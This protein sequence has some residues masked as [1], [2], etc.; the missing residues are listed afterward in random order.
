[1]KIYKTLLPAIILI[2]GFLLPSCDERMEELNTDPL[3]LSGIPNEYM[4]ASAVRKTFGDPSDEGR[5]ASQYA[6]VYVTNSEWRR[7]DGYDD[8]HSQDIYKMMFSYWYTEPVRYIRR[9]LDLTASGPDA[10]TV[11]HA[12][13]MVVEALC[14]SQITD[15]WGDVPYTEAGRGLEGIMYP[16]YDE[17]EFIY[18]SLITRLGEAIHVLENADPSEGYPE[19]DPIY[20]N[21]HDKWIRFANSIRFRLAMRARFADPSGSALVITECMNLDKFIETNDQNY[22]LKHEDSES[23]ELYN[24][25]WNVRQHQELRISEKL[26]DWLK[27]NSDPRLSVL[28]DTTPAGDYKGFINGLN[29]VEYGKYPWGDYS[30]PGSILFTKSFSQYLMCASEVWFLRAEAALFSLAPG[31]ANSLYRE[32]IQANLDLWNISEESANSF[33][34]G[35]VASLSGTQEQQFEQICNQAWVAFIPDFY[36]AWFNIRRTG[37]PSIAQRTDPVKYALGV[38]NGYLPKRFKYPSVEYNTNKANLDQAI[39]R[40]G[41][42]KIDTPVWWDVRGN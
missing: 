25:W 2:S 37:Y 21:N 26:V 28:A 20:D 42:D 38:T 13:A 1:M 5:F 30:A 19:S 8:F 9:V 3:S 24:P 41:A 35:A 22:E 12:M 14:F 27:L 4:F 32:G 39:N 11:Q 23:S 29:D 40:Q 10:D 33:M 6:H 17:Q 34:A 16:H 31:D 18:S 7:A 36:Q 15:L